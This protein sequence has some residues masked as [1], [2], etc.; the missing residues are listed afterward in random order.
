[1]IAASTVSGCI[2][3]GFHSGDFPGLPQFALLMIAESG[4][5]GCSRCSGIVLVIV[6]VS[7]LLRHCIRGWRQSS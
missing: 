7:G 3:W 2:W 4:R 5:S 1:M 6:Q